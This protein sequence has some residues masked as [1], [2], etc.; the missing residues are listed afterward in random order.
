MEGLKQVA[1]PFGWLEDAVLPH[2]LP[3][4]SGSEGFFHSHAEGRFGE[5]VHIFDLQRGECPIQVG[6]PQPLPHALLLLRLFSAFG[7]VSTKLRNR[8]GNDRL[9]KLVTIYW[10]R[11]VRDREDAE[12]GDWLVKEMG[13]EEE[14]D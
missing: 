4:F 14:E 3:V 9:A 2:P 6:L 7:L 1:Q 10:H 13:L 8:L 12:E 11:A 5:E